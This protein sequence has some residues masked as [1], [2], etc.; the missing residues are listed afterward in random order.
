MLLSLIFIVFSIIKYKHNTYKYVIKYN[1]KFIINKV[2]IVGDSR[3]ELI[4]DKRDRLN[5]PDYFIFDAKSGA[6]IK[7]FKQTGLP[8]LIEILSNKKDYY[9]YHV[10]FNLGVNDIDYDID[11]I[12]RVKEYYGMY[13]D[14]IV[15][16]KDISFYFLSVNPIDENRIYDKFPSN[17]RTNSEIQIFNNYI[18]YSLNRDNFSNAKYCDSYNDLSFNLPDGLHY[19]DKT[20]QDIIN[21][22]NN[23]CI[24]FK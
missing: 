17:S 14:L 13:R 15:Q 22:I 1:S 5:I 18:K 7:W 19:S 24:D 20:D 23:Y 3:M 6:Y 8:D 11:L 10:V 2:I 4:R 9:H 16:N 12:E 21:Y